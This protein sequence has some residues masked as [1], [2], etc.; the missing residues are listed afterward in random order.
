MKDLWIQGLVYS[1][2]YIRA[3]PQFRKLVHKDN[4]LIIRN[5]MFNDKL[6]IRQIDSYDPND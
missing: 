4:S 1:T 5:I 6:K 3:Y 2:K